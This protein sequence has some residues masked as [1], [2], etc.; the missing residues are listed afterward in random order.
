MKRYFWTLFLFTPIFLYSQTYKNLVLDENTKEP[1]AF[2]NIRINEGK[3]GTISDIDGKFSFPLSENIQKITFTYVGYQTL[4]LD[5]SQLQQ[6]KGPILLKQ[7]SFKIKE[8]EVLPG[9]NPA[10][11]IIDAAIENREINNPEKASEFYYQ[12]YNKLIFSVKPDSIK[13]KEIANTPFEKLDSNTQEALEF[14]DSMHLFMMESIS[15]RNHIPPSNSKEVILASRISGFKNPT[16][17]LIGTQLQSFSLYD[18]YIKL[19]S[20]DYLSP[21]SKGS[22]SKYLFLLEDTTFV[23]EDTVFTISYRP[24]KGKNF[25]GLY[26]F[27]SINT[28]QFAIQNFI[29]ETIDQ[30]EINVKIQQL[31]EK[32]DDKQWFPVQLNTVLLFESIS[33]SNFYFFGEGKSYLDSIALKS[34]ISKKEFDNVV[35][36][37]NEDAGQKDS[38]FWNSY[39]K[40]ELSEQEQNTY[41]VIDSIGEKVNFDKYFL[42]VESLAKGAIPIGPVDIRLNHLLAFN[43][44]EG[45]RLGI[46]AETNDK[47]HKNLSLGVYIAYGFRDKATKYGSYLSWEKAKGTYIKSVLRYE[48]DVIESGGTNFINDR[49]SAFSSE[50]LRNYFINLMDSRE[51]YQLDIE[52]HPLKDVQA[53]VFI[54][55]QQRTVN[56]TY[57]YNSDELTTTSVRNYQFD[58]TE[59]GINIRYSPGEKY[60]KMFGVK[61]PITYLNPVFNIKF[62]R[63]LDQD[64]EGDFEYNRL[65]F[66]FHKAFKVRNLGFTS[67]RINAGYIDNSLPITALYRANGILSK[68][69]VIAA[70]FNFQ[71]VEPLEFFHDQFVGFF[72]KHSFKSLLLKTKYFK[73]EVALVTNIGWG[74]MRNANRHQGLDLNRMNLG[75]F[76]S[77]IQ[78]DRLF[79]FID[80]L[81]EE[82]D[83]NFNLGNFGV[84]AYYRYGAYSNSE[85]EDNLAIK[86]TYSIKF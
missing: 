78:F 62:S 1:L 27:L 14:V 36:S 56:R 15:E 71:T 26:G 86:A 68:R 42:I 28:D 4:N 81:L 30:E 63:G 75:F 9:V 53:S 24:R 22:T 32:V 54:N 72:F 35:L 21:I 7:T 18:T 41:R 61:R 38:T 12:S 82:S 49:I 69:A 48:N 64:F 6:I 25:E 85:F 5:R 31:Y 60:V 16:F 58:L 52:F 23:G 84:G 19:F 73:P 44:Y 34:R 51:L 77:G 65:D 40:E 46:G 47:I 70:D 79:G 11:R 67:F 50:S 43:D 80:R 39:R 29:A 74:D 57:S 2:V 17:S 55:H 37:I 20:Y 59:A 8:V 10:H 76:E 33:E 3:T 13:E 45:F 66:K 83:L